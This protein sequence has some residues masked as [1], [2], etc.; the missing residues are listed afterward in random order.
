MTQA[1]AIARN[2]E[3]ARRA[4]HQERAAILNSTS[5]NVMDTSRSRGQWAGGRTT[6]TKAT[7]LESLERLQWVREMH[8]VEHARDRIGASLPDEMRETLR[9]AIMLNVSSGKRYPFERLYVVGIS[10][11][12]FYR[13]RQRFLDDIAAELSRTQPK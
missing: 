7:K 1:Q 8:A 10:R 6:E 2:Y 9:K 5:G 4:Y 13:F 11:R 3:Q 12:T